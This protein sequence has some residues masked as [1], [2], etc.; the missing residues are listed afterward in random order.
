MQK[1]KIMKMFFAWQDEKEQAWLEQMAAHG[2]ILDEIG[3][4]LYTFRK[5]MPQQMHYRLDYQEMKQSDLQEYLGLFDDAGWKYLGRLT[6]WFYFA[7]NGPETREIYT[8]THSKI[9]K[10]KRILRTLFITSFPSIYYVVFYSSLFEQSNSC[11]YCGILEVLRF[12]IF[13][14]WLVMM[15]NIVRIWIKIQKLEKKIE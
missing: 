9:E 6:N 5:E 15:F 1:K 8:D 11:S 3:F 13:F 12:V 10:Y 4:F 14:L 7:S 2:W